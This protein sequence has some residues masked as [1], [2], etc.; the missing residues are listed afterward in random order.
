M[1][2]KNGIYHKRKIKAILV[3]LIMILLMIYTVSDDAEVKRTKLS[4]L[5]LYFVETVNSCI[6]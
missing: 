3:L 1:K 6:K 4:I 5:I 2:N